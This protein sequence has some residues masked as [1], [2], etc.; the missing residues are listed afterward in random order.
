MKRSKRFELD[1][2]DVSVGGSGFASP[3]NGSRSRVQHV[4]SYEVTLYH[5][6]TGVSV[7]GLLPPARRSKGAW[8]VEYA[9]LRERL[10]AD[11]EQAVARR[12]RLPGR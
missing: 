6:P 3:L 4:R 9:K 7:T 1:P 11:L 10:M 2:A 12:L 8:R 5:K